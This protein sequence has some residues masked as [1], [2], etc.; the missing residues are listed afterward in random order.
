MRTLA[1]LAL[2]PLAACSGSGDAKTAAASG[3]NGSKT[4]AISGFSAVDSTGPDDVDVRVGSGFSIRAEGDTGI[5]QRLEIVKNGD[6]LEIRR[7][8]NSGFSWGSSER[9]HLKI[10]VTMPRITAASTT[11]SGDMAIDHVEGDTFKVDATGSGD[12]AIASMNVQRADFSLT[13]SG[14]VSTSGSAKT[15]SFSIQGSGDIDAPKLTLTQAEVSVM[16]SGGVT[17]AVNGPA[18][19]DVMGSG[20]VTLTGGAKCTSSKMGSGDIT[21]S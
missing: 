21:C 10:Y 1:L 20:D 3:V 15:G 2:A 14:S 7:K 19:V 17:A 11:G 8:S 13:G 5:M 12:L 18:K 16:G 9:G 6:T 4:F